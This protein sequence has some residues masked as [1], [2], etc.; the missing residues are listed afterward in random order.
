MSAISSNDSTSPAPVCPDCGHR[1][2]VHDNN[3]G[4]HHKSAG[5]FDCNC[6]M[7]ERRIKLATMDAVNA[8]LAARNA[9]LEAALSY[10]D[11]ITTEWDANK[12]GRLELQRK[13]WQR[14]GEIARKALQGGAS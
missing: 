5:A 7:T 9:E 3:I 8:T 4:C 1:A 2:S 10:I 12:L 13:R 6:R 14:C 11:R